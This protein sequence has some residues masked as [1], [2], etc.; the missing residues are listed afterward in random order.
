MTRQQP[1]TT[2]PIILHAWQVRGILDGTVTQLWRPMEAGLYRRAYHPYEGDLDSDNWPMAC[3]GVSGCLTRVECPWGEAGARLWCK[4]AWSLIDDHES[5]VCV[6][7]VAGPGNDYAREWLT[8]GVE[9]VEAARKFYGRSV[10]PA[11]HMPRWASRILLEIEQVSALPVQGVTEADALTSGIQCFD[12]GPD[13]YRPSVRQLGYGREKLALGVMTQTA[14]D[15]FA[16][17]WGR[18][19]PRHPYASN[20]MAWRLVVRRIES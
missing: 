18:D 11:A 6:G 2:R 13:S 19:N 9:R 8:I 4:E 3:A 10:I 16:R 1:T 7:Y 5:A 15:A 14:R 12:Y 17:H 20:P